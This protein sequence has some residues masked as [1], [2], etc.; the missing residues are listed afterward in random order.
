MP[1]PVQCERTKLQSTWG[2]HAPGSIDGL[3]IRAQ[4]AANRDYRRGEL[5][6]GTLRLTVLNLIGSEPWSAL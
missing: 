5:Q 1:H 3:S 6:V 4:L 2:V